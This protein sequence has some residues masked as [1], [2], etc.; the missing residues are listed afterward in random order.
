[1]AA[2]RV[3]LWARLI[4]LLAYVSLYGEEL[5]LLGKDTAPDHLAM[6]E[7]L[8]DCVHAV[9]QL[10]EEMLD[11]GEATAT[12]NSSVA[13]AVFDLSYALVVQRPKIYGNTHQL[14]L[15]RL[16]LHLCLDSYGMCA[17]ASRC[18]SIIA[19]LEFC[20]RAVI[21]FHA[22][23]PYYGLVFTTDADSVEGAVQEMLRKNFYHNGNS[24][25]A[26]LQL[27]ARYGTVL[28]ANEQSSVFFAWSED[29]RQVTFAAKTICIARL[30]AMAAA[31]VAQANKHMAQL[32]LL[33]DAEAVPALDLQALEDSINSRRPGDSFAVFS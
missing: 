24:A 28:A 8:D 27:L 6:D 17:P 30:Q 21:H 16:F 14:A 15:P 3:N 13:A 9:G 20:M 4:T 10:Y 11:A 18:T 33:Q 12:L 29:R 2:Q 32:L 31:A 1:T 26:W 25:S 5:A 7:L 23:E 19:G 22:F